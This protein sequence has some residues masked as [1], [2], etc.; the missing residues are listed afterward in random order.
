MSHRFTI[1]IVPDKGSRRFSLTFSYV[2]LKFFVSMA[3]LL[4]CLA[5]YFCVDYSNLVYIRSQYNEI[6]KENQLIRAEA[7]LLS[8]NLD[9]V[10]TSL[11]HVQDFARKVNEIVNIKINTVKV[12]TGIGP[13]SN[14][15]MENI[16]KD[17][18]SK[19][20]QDSSYPLGINVDNLIFNPVFIKVE[21]TQRQS[22]ASAIEM[23]ELVAS[24]TLKKSLLA[25]IPT[26][27]PVRGLITSGFG[28]RASPFSGYL[29][30]HR[31]I[32]I[33]AAVG[34]PIMAPADGVV[35]FAG[36]KADFGNVITIAHHKNGIVTKYA[37]N[38]QNLVTEGQ[39]IHRGDH[40]A[41]VGMTGNTTGPHVHYEVWV[42]GQ[43]EDPTNF[44]L[45]ADIALF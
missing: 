22:N 13:L 20:L 6:E 12:K 26:T 35:T 34:T 5:I 16:K 24:L 45:D 38:A 27:I 36:S 32:D 9:T 29:T 10:K 40:I 18:K 15:D 8:K 37:H 43:A 44:I 21:E 30:L 2:G 33:A 1:M 31:G 25:A 42:N 28:R 19:L 4:F 7:R 14:E 23:E 17:T 11:S 41:S 3:A 39:V